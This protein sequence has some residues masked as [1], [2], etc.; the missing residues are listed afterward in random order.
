[1][2]SL[3]RSHSVVLYPTL[4]ADEQCEQGFCAPCLSGALC[5]CVVFTA[6]TTRDAALLRLFC[7]FA[8]KPMQAFAPRGCPPRVFDDF[9][10]RIAAARHQFARPPIGPIGAL[11]TLTEERWGVAVELACGR[12]L[13]AFV[14][15]NF[16]D[17]RLLQVHTSCNI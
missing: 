10:N 11:L 4:A 9:M 7:P 12:A 16:Q 17:Q 1:M 5:I 6:A 13:G 8:D 3:L 2:L 15:H 14:T